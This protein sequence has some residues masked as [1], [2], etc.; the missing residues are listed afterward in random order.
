MKLITRHFLYASAF[1]FLSLV[2]I[3]GL[4]FVFWVVETYLQTQLPD[5]KWLT[6]GLFL[7]IAFSFFV[8]MIP[9]V[10][11]TNHEQFLIK[12]FRHYLDYFLYFIGTVFIWGNIIVWTIVG[13]TM[14]LH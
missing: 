2:G 4:Q 3:G 10:D 14:L 11:N 6:Y 8:A 12:S 5:W 9:P 1:L 7:G 13:I